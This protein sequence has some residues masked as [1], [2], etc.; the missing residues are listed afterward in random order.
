MPRLDL[1]SDVVVTVGKDF[2]D[3]ASAYNKFRDDYDLRG[4]KVRVLTLV[5]TPP[6]SLSGKVCGQARPSDFEFVGCANPWDAPGDNAMNGIGDGSP[7]IFASDDARFGI[8]GLTLRNPTGFG[9][10]VGQ[11]QVSVRD[12]WFG[13]FG[14]AA[15]DVCG[16]QS[17]IS[18]A[19]FST[20]LFEDTGAFAIAE[21]GDIFIASKIYISGAP[22]F[23]NAFVQ[24][25]LGGYVDLTGYELALPGAATGVKYK[26]F[27]G[28]NIEN[29]GADLPGNLPGQINGGFYQ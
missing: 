19:G 6:F 9:V 10:A 28:A 20:I 23:R 3:C 17:L 24:A 22:L 25:D 29:N 27:S 21:H 18:V 26:S 2:P 5:N 8:A 11:G 1:D 12:C 16:S 15:L 4:K 14:G 7:L 13:S